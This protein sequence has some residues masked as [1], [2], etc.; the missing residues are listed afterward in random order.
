[1]APQHP[2]FL[3]IDKGSGDAGWLKLPW[4]SEIEGVLAAKYPEFPEVD[5]HRNPLQGWER[6]G[7]G[8]GES[9]EDESHS[10]QKTGEG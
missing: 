8:V 1:M 3:T 5:E 10:W 6:W 7:M 2:Y 4:L 9:S